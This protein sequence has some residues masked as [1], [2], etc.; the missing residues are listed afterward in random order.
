MAYVTPDIYKEPE[1][2]IMVIARYT[3]ITNAEL[4]LNT[5]IKRDGKGKYI[6]ARGECFR[7]TS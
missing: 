7:K 3:L 2:F 1:R 6:V 5:F 4:G